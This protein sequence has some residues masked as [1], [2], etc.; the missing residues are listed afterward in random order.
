MDDRYEEVEENF[1]ETFDWAYSDPKPDRSWDSLSKW[2]RGDES[3]YWVCGKAGSGKSTL[4]RYLLDNERTMEELQLW[5]GDVQ[6]EVASFFFWNSGTTEQRS[7]AGLRSLL[8]QVLRDRKRL[9]PCVLPELWEVEMSDRLT[10][11]QKPAELPAWTFKRLKKAFER[12]ATQKLMP[13]KTC[14]FI[15]GLDEYDGKF[16]D[17]IEFCQSLAT[18]PNIK[19]CVSSRPLV[20]FDLH[21]QNKAL[22]V[23]G[24]SGHTFRNAAKIWNSLDA[25]SR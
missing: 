8:H 24:F 10:Y 21:L 11:F 1:A 22:D 18:L 19:L 5:S 14:L 20:V 6:L 23:S 4:M 2:L 25:F 3:L 13:V 7:Q 12:L 16:P 17:I 9:I 15:D